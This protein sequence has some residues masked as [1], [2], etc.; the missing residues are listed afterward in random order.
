MITRQGWI[1]VDLDGTLARGHAERIG[2]PVDVM[3][4]RVKRWLAD[5]YEVR[6]FTARMSER[7]PKD[8]EAQARMIWE[9]TREHVGTPLTATCCK[10]YSTIEIWDDRARQVET[11]TGVESVE[12]AFDRGYWHRVAADVP[13]ES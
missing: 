8:R 11:N 5:G 9:W 7:D 6:V 4:E 1:G 10:D 13:G 3:V 12:A 2:P